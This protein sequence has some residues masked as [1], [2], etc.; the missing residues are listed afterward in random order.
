[1]TDFWQCGASWWG[2][3]EGVQRDCKI[4]IAVTKYARGNQSFL[5]LRNEAAHVVVHQRPLRVLLLRL[6]KHAGDE[7]R[8]LSALL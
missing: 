1:M 8:G 3:L 6:M 4:C 7:T 5:D 2:R